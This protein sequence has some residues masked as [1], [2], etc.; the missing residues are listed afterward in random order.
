M[1]G[2]RPYGHLT[3]AAV[4]D[5]RL[6]AVV[7]PFGWVDDNSFAQS[8]GSNWLSSHSGLAPLIPPLVRRIIL[9]A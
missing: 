9:I 4:K 7:V 1:I 5:D 3:H 2:E 8:K 6:G